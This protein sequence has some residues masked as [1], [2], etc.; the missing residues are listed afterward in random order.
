[1]NNIMNRLFIYWHTKDKNI[2][3]LH[4]LTNI[5]MLTVAVYDY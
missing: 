3:Y 4:Y 1:M 5:Q 2:K